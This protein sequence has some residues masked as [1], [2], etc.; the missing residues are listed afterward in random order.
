MVNPRNKKVHLSLH[1]TTRKD[2]VRTIATQRASIFIGWIDRA[3][4][5]VADVETLHATRPAPEQRGSIQI[6]C[7]LKGSFC[8]VRLLCL[9]PNPPIS[10]HAS[11]RMR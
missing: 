6:L 3:S 11:L 2:E 10:S 5:K 8:P 7:V 1:Q 4:V 9:V